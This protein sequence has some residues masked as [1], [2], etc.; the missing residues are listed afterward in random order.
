M[1][2]NILK[3]SI[4]SLLFLTSCNIND[5]IFTT[6]E[7]ININSTNSNW[8][9]LA[10]M[11]T[12]RYNAQA[13]YIDGKIYVSGGL[14]NDI[15]VLN[16][17]EAFDTL[18]KNWKKLSP[19]PFA[20]YIHSTVSIG[21]K[22]YF[23]GG[24]SINQEV[25]NILQLKNT[26]GALNTLQSYDTKL[27]KWENLKSM[28]FESFM[29]ASIV[30]NGN[31]FVAGGGN[32]GKVL[33]NFEMYNPKNNTW[34]KLADM[35]IPRVWGKFFQKD[36]YLYIVGGSQGSNSYLN[37]I[38]RYDIEKNT[39]KTNILPNMEIPRW[40]FGLSYNKDGVYIA[41]GS[42]ENGFVG[43][44]EYLNFKT[45][46]WIYLPNIEPKR[47]GVDLVS[48]DKGLYLFGMDPWNTNDTLFLKK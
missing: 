38:D 22:I 43:E 5:N 19:M 34:K 2:K 44:V 6:E 1:K 37:S 24:Y 26:R 41:A 33:S 10:S 23:I 17:F 4:I 16:S 42:N 15:G 48:T 27:D 36:R 20:R 25:N 32:K 28:N 46:K 29:P 11:P 21:D 12:S 8:E 13:N 14:N 45:N 18:T 40:G 47:S 35:P 7:K 3:I 39:W 30:Y 9:I 31:V